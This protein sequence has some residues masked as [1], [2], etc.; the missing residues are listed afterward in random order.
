MAMYL[1]CYWDLTNVQDGRPQRV[2]EYGHKICL[3]Y[4]MSYLLAVLRINGLIEQCSTIYH[5]AVEM[6][7]FMR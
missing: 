5:V 3:N 7:H 4:E 6:N 2:A 1:C